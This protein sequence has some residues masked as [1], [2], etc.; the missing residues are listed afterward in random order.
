M[1]HHWG[2]A[3]CLFMVLGLSLFLSTSAGYAGLGDSLKKKVQKEVGAKVDEATVVPGGETENAEKGVEGEPGA[4][5]SSEASAQGE[6]GGGGLSSVSTKFDFVPGDSV[7]LFDDFSQDELGEFPARWKLSQGTFETAESSGERWLRCAS[8]DGRI[9]MKLP[10]MASL[11]E[12]WT[13]EFDLS[14]PEASGSISVRA[15]AEGD[16]MV[17]EAVFPQGGAMAFRTGEIFSSTPYEGDA[18]GR[19]HLMFMARGR[20]LKAY[21]DH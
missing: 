10:A 16:R 21:I 19:H 6:G 3:T 7:L 1:R 4:G 20:G 11:P 15:M 17:W 5:K 18:A 13:L 8:D 14:M 2:L 12:F 9:Y